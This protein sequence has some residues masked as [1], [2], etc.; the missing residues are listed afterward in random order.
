MRFEVCQAWTDGVEIAKGG[1][2]ISDR[3]WGSRAGVQIEVAREVVL[4]ESEAPSFAAQT[5]VDGQVN[6]WAV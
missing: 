2:I 6:D 1:R 4:N 3:C 5:S